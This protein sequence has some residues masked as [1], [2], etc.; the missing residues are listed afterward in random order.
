MW[1]SCAR[2]SFASSSFRFCSVIS[3]ASILFFDFPRSQKAFRL[4]VSQPSSGGGLSVESAFACNFCF[5]HRLHCRK[6]L[7]S[8]RKRFKQLRKNGHVILGVPLRRYV[9][10][11]MPHD[12]IKLILSIYP[13]LVINKQRILFCCNFLS[14]PACGL[15]F[16]FFLLF[17]CFLILL[18]YIVHDISIGRLHKYCTRYMYNF[19]L[20]PI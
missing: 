10:L 4:V 18:Y 5:Y 17:S 19:I 20:Y 3:C 15:S 14:L 16:W 8:V 12:H 11:D 1:R 6:I 2:N 7:I 9:V 13:A